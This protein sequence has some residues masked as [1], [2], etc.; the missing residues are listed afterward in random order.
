M[1]EYIY[2][3]ISVR[4]PWAWL[5]VN[6]YKPIENRNWRTK[7]RGELLIHTS[8][9]RPSKK[10][11]KEFQLMFDIEFD[12]QLPEMEEIEFGG[13]VGKANVVDCVNYSDS[14]WFLG[15]YGWVLEDQQRIRF[16]LLKGMLKI[17]KY[18]SK[19]AICPM[20]LTA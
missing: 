20:T 14:K 8:S 16:V 11:W 5:I 19:E 13:L 12:I 4:Q 3:C 2:Q 18:H 10:A 7:Y 1:R 15:K 6:G 17:F 9:F